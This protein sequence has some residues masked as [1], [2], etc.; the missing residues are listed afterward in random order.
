LNGISKWLLT[1]TPIQ[2]SLN[3]LQAFSIYLK[4][5]PWKNTAI[6][7]KFVS[8]HLKQTKVDDKKGNS[9]EKRDLIAQEKGEYYIY[10]FKDGL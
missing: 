6:W 5:E 8:A 10:V 2:N 4:Y 1:G 3:D 9:K 7:K